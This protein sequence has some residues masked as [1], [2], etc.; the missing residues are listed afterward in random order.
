MLGR[1]C[2]R[3]PAILLAALRPHHPSVPACR[4]GAPRSGG[5][6][7]SG[8]QKL[9]ASPSRGPGVPGSRAPDEGAGRGSGPC[10]RNHRLGSEMCSCPEPSWAELGAPGPR[11]SPD[12]TVSAAGGSGEGAGLSRVPERPLGADLCSATAHPWLGPCGGDAGLPVRRAV[13][14]PDKASDPFP[15]RWLLCFPG[16]PKE[17]AQS[18]GSDGLSTELGPP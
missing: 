10:L 5:Q 17:R 4:R 2:I 3:R 12:K 7:W 14:A 18:P 8:D 11:E 6:S 15:S 16:P 9:P 13:C 1:D